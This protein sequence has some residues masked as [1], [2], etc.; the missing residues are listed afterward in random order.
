MAN[1]I[2]ILRKKAGYKN[3]KEAAS[4]LDISSSMIYQIECGYKKPSAS[5]GMRMCH[6]FG[7]KLEDIFLPYTITERDNPIQDPQ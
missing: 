3:V 1:H 5:L 4:A 6:L 2:T 7:C